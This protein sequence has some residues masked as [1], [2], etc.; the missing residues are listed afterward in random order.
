M[1]QHLTAL[2]RALGPD[3]G[4]VLVG[5]AVRDL[6]LGR[7]GGDWDLAS[8]LLPEEARKRLELQNFRVIPTGLQHGTLTVLSGPH[9]FE[10]TTFR[11]DGTYTD[12]RRPDAVTLGV[13]LEA[14]LARRDFTVNALAL[15][16]EWVGREG[17]ADHLVDPFGGLPDLRAGCLRAVGD[18]RLRFAE[19]GLRPL[20]ACRFMAQLGFEL[21]PATCAAIPGSLEVS[22]RVAVERVWV[23]LT[24]LLTGNWPR[25]GLEA[26]RG[27]GLLDLWLAELNPM[28]QST[29]QA[30]ESALA[31]VE[32]VPPEPGP[33]WAAL[34][35]GMA[36]GEL[37]RLLLERLRAPRA[38]IHSAEALIRHHGEDPDPA[39]SDAACR[40]LLRRLAEDGLAL[41]DWGRFRGGM[42]R[43]RGPAAATTLEVH[44]NALDRLR[45]LAAAAPPLS[46]RQLALD[47]RAL[48]RITGR[49]G[50]PWLGHLQAWLLERVLDDPDLNT[51]ETLAV[52]VKSWP[53]SGKPRNEG[54][55]EL[56]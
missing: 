12:G 5:G 3:S 32:A 11:G 46:V 13:D 9:A 19:D 15:P 36:G 43:D 4:L 51:P 55:T 20:R 14:D 28:A 49:S 40:R 38:T 41:E 34:L 47:G 2:H 25:R 53:C 50:G 24:K 23:E 54:D 21:D 33:R 29:A 26:L 44:G 42:L 6:L 31:G 30:W 17:W 22:R 1:L 45:R 37:A 7:P 39:W 35:H 8:R 56:S 10:L 18:P 16:A 48:M 52:L 27:T